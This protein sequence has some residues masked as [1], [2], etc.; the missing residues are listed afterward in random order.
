MLAARQ[1]RLSSIS[2]NRPLLIVD[3]NDQE[4]SLLSYYTEG[5]GGLSIF[6]AVFRKI[7]MNARIIFTNTNETKGEIAL[8]I[9]PGV[10]LFRQV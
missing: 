9:R 4:T 8:A 10:Q 7:V 6:G 1:Q 5:K 3:L 2:P